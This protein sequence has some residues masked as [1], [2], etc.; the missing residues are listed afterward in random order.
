[1]AI[2]FWICGAAV[3]LTR[4]LS[5]KWRLHMLVRRALPVESIPLT[6]HLR[7]LCRDYG[8]RREVVVLASRELDVPIATGVLDPKITHQAPRRV[9]PIPC[10]RCGGAVLVQSFGLVHRA[11]YAR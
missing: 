2:L 6:S 5:L 4:M 10:G 7:W 8:I 3:C 1:M 11:G 9:Y